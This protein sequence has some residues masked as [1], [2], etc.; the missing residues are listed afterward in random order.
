MGC[1]SALT[2]CD[3][4]SR[5]SSAPARTG[6]EVV[7]AGLGTHLVP[8]ERLPQLRQALAGLGD[9]AADAQ[10]V[11]QA[12]AS[13]QARPAALRPL[14]TLEAR[15]LT[16]QRYHVAWTLSEQTSQVETRC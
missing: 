13:H 6:A 8:S 5:L 2:M 15:G 3:K 1:V 16:V 9:R 4:L 14:S 10:A 7:A 12:L 11:G